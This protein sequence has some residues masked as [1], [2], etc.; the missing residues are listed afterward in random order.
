M[1]KGWFSMDNR[2]PNLMCFGRDLTNC[3]LMDKCPDYQECEKQYQ[4]DWLRLF[5]TDRKG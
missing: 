5:D 2:Y 4:E 3:T 1:M